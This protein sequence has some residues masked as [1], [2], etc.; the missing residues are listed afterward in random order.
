MCHQVG[1]D[2]YSYTDGGADCYRSDPDPINRTDSRPYRDSSP[3]RN[4]YSI[5]DTIDYAYSVN[6][7]YSYSGI[8]YA[9]DHTDSIRNPDSDSKC[10]TYAHSAD[11]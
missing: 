9:V 7:T 10:Y 1:R 11:R 5:G 3:V 2:T 4:P 6:Y 8:A